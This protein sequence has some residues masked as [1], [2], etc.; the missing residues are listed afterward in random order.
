MRPVNHRSLDPVPDSLLQFI[1]EID[2]SD[3]S[4]VFEVEV[5]GQ[6]CAMKL[7]SS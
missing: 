3:A 4:S 7:V 5:D 1:G 6:K 2:R